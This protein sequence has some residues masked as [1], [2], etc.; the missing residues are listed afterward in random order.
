MIIK[1]S[2][3]AVALKPSI[4]SDP[5]FTFIRVAEDQTY[6]GDLKKFRKDTELGTCTVKVDCA[7]STSKGDVFL[8]SRTLAGEVTIEPTVSEA[9]GTRNTRKV[10]S[11]PLNKRTLQVVVLAFM[12][13]GSTKLLVLGH[14]W[15]GFVSFM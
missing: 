12:R 14:P 15:V 1:P 10:F 13:E 8:F 9:N 3:G 4:L 11:S 2:R 7:R 6:A 5:S